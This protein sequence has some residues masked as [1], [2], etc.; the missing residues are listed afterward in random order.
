MRPICDLYDISVG[1]PKDD[2][3][4][5]DYTHHGKRTPWWLR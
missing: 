3:I 4:Y 1:I 2:L 5:M